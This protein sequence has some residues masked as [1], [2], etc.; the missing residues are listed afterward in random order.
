MAMAV[1]VGVAAGAA[2]AAD[3][4]VASG[5]RGAPAAPLRWS[6]GRVKGAGDLIDVACPARTLCVAISNAGNVAVSNQ[7]WAGAA[8]WRVVSGLTILRAGGT[9]QQQTDAAQID[10]ERGSVSGPPSRFSR[11]V[12]LSAHS[13]K[14]QDGE[15]AAAGPSSAAPGQPR[16]LLPHPSE[17]ATV[18]RPGLRLDRDGNAGGRDRH[19]VDVPSALP[20]QR[21]P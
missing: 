8:T 17:I 16:R 13:D 21:V 1:L 14:A 9:L 20:R 10:Q 15:H 18:V 3:A 6:A 4:G 5:D 12:D 7:P 11:D 2:G 19:R